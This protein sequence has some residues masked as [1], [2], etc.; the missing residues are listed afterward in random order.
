MKTTDGGI[1]MQTPITTGVGAG[2]VVVTVMAPAGL[3]ADAA[4]A[5]QKI[6]KLGKSAM[7]QEMYRC[8]FLTEGE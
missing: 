6:V 8:A 1:L 2:Q 7:F 3:E 4:L 5:S